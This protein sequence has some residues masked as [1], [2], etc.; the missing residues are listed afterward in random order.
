MGKTTTRFFFF[1]GVTVTGLGL[2]FLSGIPLTYALFVL[3][4]GLGCLLLS[5]TLTNTPLPASLVTLA[6]ALSLLG[7]TLSMIQYGKLLRLAL[8]APITEPPF[9][10][11]LIAIMALWTGAG[12][13]VAHAAGRKKPLSRAVWGKVY[14]SSIAMLV[15]T[16]AVAPFLLFPLDSPPRERETVLALCLTAAVILISEFS[17]RLPP[18]SA[19]TCPLPKTE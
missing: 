18:T 11:M 3:T 1:T 2:Y 13:T 10:A 9:T 6:G 4:A 16:F 12:S 7:I 15:L 5:E 8:T 19:E 14:W 17:M